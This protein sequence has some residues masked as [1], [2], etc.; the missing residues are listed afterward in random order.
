MSEKEKNEKEVKKKGISRREFL[1]DAGLVVGSVGTVTLLGLKGTTVRAD[2]GTEGTDTTPTDTTQVDI[3]QQDVISPAASPDP[4]TNLTINGQTYTVQNPNNWTLQRTLQYTL[5]LTGNAKT[6]CDRGVCGSCTVI[7][8]GKAVLSCMTLT[9]EC[10][11]RN[12]QTIEGIS[13]ANH[14][15][16]AAYANNDALQCGYCTPGFVTAAKALLDSNI[17]PTAADIKDALAGQICCCGTYPRHVPAILEAA[18]V[19]R[20]QGGH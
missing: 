1:R 14:P 9:V 17:N 13:A 10:A 15:L 5:G 8:D 11:G 2:D 18:A 6:M 12:I 19:L 20:A 7:I 3:T 4:I 16:I